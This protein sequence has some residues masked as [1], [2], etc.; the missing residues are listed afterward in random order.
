MGEL[1]DRMERDLVLRG[2]TENTC[3][4]YLQSVKGLAAYYRRPP[5]Q[6]SDA[7]VRQYQ[8]YLIRERKLAWSSCRLAACGLR[9]FYRVT[10]GRPWDA[11]QI[12]MPKGD[13]KRPAI[14]SREEVWRLF[15]ITANRKHRAL[16]MTTYA[17]GL[18]VCEVV[19]LRV[20]NL[21]SD[22]ML[23]RVEGGK[24]RK[25]RDTLLSEQ[26]LVELRKYWRMYRPAHWLFPSRTYPD[27][28][29]DRKSAYLIY[30]QA[31][32]RARITKAGGIHCLRHAFATHLIEAGIDVVTMQQLLGHSNLR[33]TSNY[34]H[35]AHGGLARSRSAFDLLSRPPKT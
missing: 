25:D 35:L 23:I 14:L 22:R 7:E 32:A 11:M 18:R 31:K 1:R 10:L 26:L 12:P 30:C 19:R 24:G 13:R 2:L 15:E 27:R 34:L 21:D 4:S 9:F 16:L 6:L 20:Q 33:T 17:A 29:L 28:P 8:L 5:D 3:K